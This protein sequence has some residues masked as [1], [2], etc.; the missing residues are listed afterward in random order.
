MPIQH[1][2]TQGDSVARL[3]AQYGFFPETLWNH[4]ENAALK[5]LRPSM[6]VLAPGDVLHIPDKREGQFS[7]ETGQRHVFRRKAVPMLFR[8]QLLDGRTPRANRPYRL[9]VDGQPLEGLTSAQGCIERYIPNAAR[10]GRLVVDDGIVDVKLDFGHM[11]PV[12]LPA[13]VRKRLVN[14]GHVL[15]DEAEDVDGAQL[16]AAFRQFQ[17]RMGLPVTG[18]LDGIT[19][20][21]LNRCHDEQNAFAQAASGS[22]GED[23]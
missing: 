6:N 11:D 20:D 3:A 10:Q 15:P 22:P 1:E 21:T 4:P 13:G 5:A 23:R 17:R 8:V 14:L 19:R 12:A 2:V 16:A 18:E 9:E 7:C